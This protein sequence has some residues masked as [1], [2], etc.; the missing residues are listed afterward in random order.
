[1]VNILNTKAIDGPPESK[2]FAQ[3]FGAFVRE[4]KY[5]QLA[6]YFISSFSFEGNDLGQWRAYADN[7]R[8][9][10]TWL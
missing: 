1:V 2:D 6:H 4:E 10:C 7:G 9:L 3:A 5:K 8:G